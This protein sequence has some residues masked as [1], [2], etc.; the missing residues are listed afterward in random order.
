MARTTGKENGRSIST[1]RLGGLG[2]IEVVCAP[3]EKNRRSGGGR[4]ASR[5]GFN[6]AIAAL[7]DDRLLGISIAP[8][9]GAEGQPAY[10][11]MMIQIPRTLEEV[12]RR[13]EEVSVEE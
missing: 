1:G 9:A 10:K 5:E 4:T 13:F 2:C 6:R 7:P 8:I 3:A 11:V 12:M